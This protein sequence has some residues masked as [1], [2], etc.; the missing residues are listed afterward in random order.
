MADRNHT[1]L[2]RREDLYNQISQIQREIDSRDAFVDRADR[3]EY[4]RRVRER[5]DSSTL[6]TMAKIAGLGFAAYAVGR[7][8]PK[9]IWVDALHKMGQ[10]GRETFGRA[11][12]ARNETLYQQLARRGLGKGAARAEARSVGLADF[13]EQEARPFINDIQSTLTNR[14][15]RDF[16][17]NEVRRRLQMKFA[18][19]NT[20]RLTGLTVADVLELAKKP[21]FEEFR[22]M[23]GNSL[24]TL[25]DF[26]AKLGDDTAWFDRLSVDNHLFRTKSGALPKAM[27]PTDIRDIRWASRRALGNAAYNG[28]GFQIPFVGFKP[29]DL[30][31]PFF[32]L[33]N[34]DQ[35]SFVR[36]GQGQKLAE[37]V[38]TPGSGTSYL[39]G[40]KVHHFGTSGVKKIASDRT[41]RA[42]VIDGI[43]KANLARLGKHPL[44]RVK[45]TPGSFSENLQ[46]LVG[47][48]PMYREEAFA[49]S[50]FAYRARAVRGLRDGSV[51]WKPRDNLRLVDLPVRQRAAI[52]AKAGR[53]LADDHLIKNPYQKLEQ[54]SWAERQKAMLGHS[55]AG[56]FV[57]GA[58]TSL[59]KTGR[60]NLRSRRPSP[61][62]YGSY[63]DNMGKRHHVSHTVFE[64]K[65]STKLNLLGHHATER[66]NQLIGATMGIGFRPSSGRFG[67]FWNY[68]KIAAIG[69]TFNP[70]SGYLVEAA[71]YVNYMFE[72]LTGGFGYLSEGVGID[73]IGIKAFEGIT[74]GA[75][76][77]KD[78]LGI[79]AG[80]RYLEDLFPGSIQSPL[81]GLARTL[82]PALYGMKGGPA[83]MLAGL[84]VSVLSGGA[85][86]VFGTNLLGAGTTTT[87]SELL[88]LYSGDRKERIRKSRWWGMGRQSFYGEDTDRF[89]PHWV[90]L[91]KSDWEYTDTLYGSKSEY[92]SHASSLPTFHNLFGLGK[93]K[94]YFAQMHAQSR[95]Y[96][97]APS[98]ANYSAALGPNQIQQGPGLGALTSAGYLPPTLGTYPIGSQTDIAYR[99]AKGMGEATEL[100]GIYKFLGEMALG[101]SDYGP[102]LANA[103]SITDTSRLYWD[104]DIGGMFGMTELLRR[105]VLPPNDV[106]A[107]EEV[108]TVPNQMPTF[109]PGSRSMFMED[110]DYYKDYS[111]GDPYTKIKGGEYR[112]PGSGYESVNELH[113]GE[114][115]V[116][117]P[118]D[119]LLI[120]SDV[121]PYSKAFN[122]FQRIVGN[123]EL[124]EEWKEKVNRALANRNIK[125]QGIAADFTPRRFTGG[126]KQ[127]VDDATQQVKY[128]AL[129]RFLGAQYEHLTMDALPELGRMVP[130]GTLVTHKL[131]PHHT[132]EQDY[133]ERQVY[134]SRY[135]NWHNPYEGF[136]RPKALTL[137]NENPLTATV[138]GGMLGLLSANPATRATLGV[139]G[140]LGFGAAS[141]ARGMYYG[142]LEGGYVPEFRRREEDAL[143][144]FDKLEYLRLEKAANRARIFGD[145][146]AANQYVRLQATSTMVGLDYTNPAALVASRR[147]VPRNERPYLDSFIN[148]APE[149]RENILRMSPQ[150]M[151]DIYRNIWER[152]SVEIDK[153][154]QMAEFM[155]TN[156]IPDENWEGWNPGIEKW[157][158]MSRTMDT[159]NNSIAMDLH[160]QSISTAM[161]AQT[162]M[163]FEGTLGVDLG[164]GIS[165]ETRDWHNASSEKV[166]MER[167][168]L[169]QG[170]NNPRVGAIPAGSPDTYDRNR[171]RIRRTKQH[172]VEAAIYEALR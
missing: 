83:G 43:A 60:F 3:D 12:Q 160:R 116:Y 37:G 158:I 169:M 164:A 76:G 106:G 22:V 35:R 110:R 87:S 127:M 26:R 100:L 105:F 32:R 30:F 61:Y 119:A 171:V 9:D 18:T 96:P 136:V 86:D 156:P 97:E 134:H 120:L 111:V 121:A 19:S 125:A 78:A 59:K 142:Q 40:G 63:Q 89:D 123:M 88:E 139:A 5:E 131:F 113:S 138:G 114:K 13:I 129:E 80:A 140:A 57:T 68:M 147:A 149:S 95:P 81:S 10:Y 161:M 46:E 85:S 103:S 99:L 133:L 137:Y 98:G 146:R 141:T 72:R 107:I 101:R 42:Q 20:G 38:F 4:N 1:N 148:A 122:E 69:A 159:A 73:D 36:L 90:A 166:D 79:T 130:F 52:E 65:L 2:D 165:R 118:V 6:G 33:A 117:D 55:T 150:Y 132:A 39:I 74:L 41:F 112:L 64:D 167:Q 71:K 170:I 23:S 115:G 102:V 50:H 126:A 14:N 45:A 82:G 25:K 70:M 28:L 157:Q 62:D 128:N 124:S 151:R 172:E 109:L 152:G 92:F 84:G 104:K 15:A 44:Q 17:E 7:T 155:M 135:S 8:I 77:I 34:N 154:A 27:K 49:G 94:D 56:E 91:A 162:R 75:A 51:R 67:A 58:G 168:A 11:I 24:R 163:Q 108:N 143:A 29:V 47:F 144:Y 54:L 16:A 145:S 31:A 66:L 48:G 21:N 53:Q 93:D 153:N